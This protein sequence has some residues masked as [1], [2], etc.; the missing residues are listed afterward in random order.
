MRVYPF[1][2]L[3]CS[4]F[5][6][7]VVDI[8]SHSRTETAEN[9]SSIVFTTL[10]ANSA[11]GMSV[12]KVIIT[13]AAAIL[14]RVLTTLSTDSNKDCRSFAKALSVFKRGTTTRVRPEVWGLILAIFECALTP[15]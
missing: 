3:T 13:E 5:Q 15:P 2:H 8:D 9:P 7:R 14:I 4:G 10:L 1:G 11:S 6:S 12:P